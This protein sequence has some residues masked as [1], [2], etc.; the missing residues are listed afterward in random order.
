MAVRQARAG[1]VMAAY[2]DVDDESCHASRRLVTKVLRE[3]SGFDG[4]VVADCIGIS[5]LYRHHNLAADQAE[6]DHRAPGRARHRAVPSDMLCF[7]GP[8]GRR[9]VEP[10]ELELQI[11]ASS[12]DIRLR[13]KARLTGYVHVLGRDW[14][15]ESRCRVE[16]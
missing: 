3:E 5:L 10:G 1:S 9:V 13:T 6:G 7:T 12:A 4:I 15:M 8:D 16:G 2:H 14:R 11:G